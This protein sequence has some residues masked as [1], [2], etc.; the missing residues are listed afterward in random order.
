MS[1]ERADAGV[2]RRPVSFGDY[3]T[4]SLYWPAAAP[5]RVQ[6]PV[7]V[8]LHPYSYSTGFAPA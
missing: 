4:A 6:L 1:D 8:W 3:V 5:A 7:V 2:A